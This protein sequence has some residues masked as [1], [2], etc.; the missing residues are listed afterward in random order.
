MFIPYRIVIQ[1]LLPTNTIRIDFK[2]AL[3]EG[4]ALREERGHLLCWNGHYSRVYVRK[5]QYHYGWDWGP[6]LITCGPW[7]PIYLERYRVRIKNVKIHPTLSEKLDAVT[8][9]IHLSID[10]RKPDHKVELSLLD[11]SG[12][13]IRQMVLQELN[14]T[15]K[16]ESPQLWYPFTH[17]EQPLYKA[18]INVLSHS[19][20]VLDTSTTT[21][22]I[23]SIQLI[24]SPLEEGSTFYFSVNKIPLFIGGSNWI[25]GDSFLPRMTPERYA[26]WIDLAV[27]GNQN[28]LRVWGGGIYE[29]EA[30]YNECDRRGVLVW[31]DFCFA[32]G[33]YPFDDTFVASVRL[34]A[35]A[36]VERLRSHPSLAI[37]A[38]N[39]EDYQIANEGLKHDMNTPEDEWV[40]TSVSGLA[41]LMNGF[42]LTLSRRR[43]PWIIYWPG[44]PFGGVDNNS[45]RTI[46]DVHIWNVSSGMLVP[47]QRYP[48]L[49]ARF[50]SEF[51]MLSCPHIA[52]VK[53]SFF[54]SQRAQIFTLRA[55][56]FEFHCKATSYEKR[57]FTNYGGE[58]PPFI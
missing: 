22:G 30:F 50:I 43:H 51:G 36:A 11:P 28:M 34:E 8:I 31:Q 42:Y 16:L 32:C 9:A 47:Y 26:R 1:R 49:S 13:T 17:G 54:D 46:G 15:I 29:D 45:D 24:Q 56:A 25:P 58:F 18:N 39:N 12:K 52:T 20:E 44:S 6:C 23:R 7:K 33:Q 14:A 5:A 3:R 27:R 2:S 55:N 57:L 41:A 21:F 48:E 40:K 38:G 4:E 37:L 19:G 35:T 10:H 53:Q